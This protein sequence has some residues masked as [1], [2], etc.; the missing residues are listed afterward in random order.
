MKSIEHKQ[1]DL[2][3]YP[4]LDWKPMQ[5]DKDKGDVLETFRQCD[6]LSGPV[7]DMHQALQERCRYSMQQAVV[8]VHL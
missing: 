8:V 5:A 7:L 4:S 2:V 6:G 3:F 1:K